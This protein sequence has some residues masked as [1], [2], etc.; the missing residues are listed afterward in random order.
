[1]GR[2][3][4]NIGD[5]GSGAINPTVKWVIE[6]CPP[7]KTH[8]KFFPYQYVHEQVYGWKTDLPGRQIRKDLDES[9]YELFFD[10]GIAVQLGVKFDA[11]RGIR[12]IN[13]R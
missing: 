10:H 6:N 5:S 9:V 7:P 11:N 13:M 2:K 8:G 12:V 3:V 4:L 1:M